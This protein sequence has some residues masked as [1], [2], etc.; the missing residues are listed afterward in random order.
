MQL[1]NTKIQRRDVPEVKQKLVA[2]RKQKD[3]TISEMKNK[4]KGTLKSLDTTGSI[5]RNRD[6]KQKDKKN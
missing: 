5:L 1:R 6:K 2:F 4:L 3:K